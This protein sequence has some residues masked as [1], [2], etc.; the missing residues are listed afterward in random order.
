[1]FTLIIHF[2]SSFAKEMWEALCTLILICFFFLI[3]V[4]VVDIVVGWSQNVFQ[5]IQIEVIMMHP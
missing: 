4:V 5:V 3:I 1:M 2:L